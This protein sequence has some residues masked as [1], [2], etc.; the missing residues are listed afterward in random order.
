MNHDTRARGRTNVGGLVAALLDEAADYC[1]DLRRLPHL[2]A[3]AVARLL[4]RAR[5]RSR[6]TDATQGAFSD[7]CRLP[8]YGACAPVGA[9]VR[10]A[11]PAAASSRSEQVDPSRRSA[12]L[13]RSHDIRRT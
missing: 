12:S 3:Q 4:R 7:V 2:A 1:A 13:G 8:A 11:V 5:R 9:Q 6:G 10:V